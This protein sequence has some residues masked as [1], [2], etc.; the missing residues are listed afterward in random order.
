MCGIFA[1]FNFYNLSLD[2]LR[3]KATALSSKMAHRGPDGWGGCGGKGWCLC[4]ERLSIVDVAGGK[5]PLLSVDG[6]I[7]MVCNGE[8]YNFKEL[9]EEIEHK[10]DILTKSDSEIIIHLWKIYGV[11]LVHKLNGMFCFILVDETDGPENR[12]VFV[13]RDHVGIKPLYMAR[14]NNGE[15]AFSSELKSIC[16]VEEL[17]EF[18]AIP[19]GHYWTNKTDSFTKF[20]DPEWD[21][22]GFKYRECPTSQEMRLVHDGLRKAIVYRLLSDVQLGILVSGGIDS[23][24]VSGVMMDHIRS[25]AKARGVPCPVVKAFSVGQE[26][27]PD[28]LAARQVAASLGLEH[29]E[30]LF[31]PEEAFEIIP[32]V[33]YHLETYEPELIRSAIPNYFLAELAAKHVKVVITGEGADEIFAG[34]RYFVDCPD[35][36]HMQKELR[37]IYHHLEIV[38]L[39]RADR[40]TMA[41]GLEARVPFLDINFLEIA[42]AIDPSKKMINEE[43][44]NKEKFY[45]RKIFE[46]Y[47]N[48]KVL[49]RTKAM[50]CEGVGKTWVSDLQAYCST[51]ISDEDYARAGEIFPNNPPQSKEEFYYRSLFEEYY[52][53]MDKFVHVWEGGCRAG[54]AAWDSSSY[55][56]HGLADTKYLD[57]GIEE[58]VEKHKVKAAL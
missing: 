3:S 42:M 40:M 31:T 19:A 9:Y 34:Y 35:S 29:Y 21:H 22:D 48:P 11:D 6:H 57:T 30:K 8:I 17:V 51:L 46:K 5:Q 53:G 2:Q 26:G 24:I 18:Q 28:I 32:K 14:G 50:Q 43:N 20:Y 58:L 23:S 7:S 52:S 25:E 38:N 55:T 56:R 54:G 15:I 36:D 27:S 41:H 47:V 39:Q 13:A 12:V 33:V 37:R 16:C 1:L 49:W 4:H 10:E 44:E 45:L